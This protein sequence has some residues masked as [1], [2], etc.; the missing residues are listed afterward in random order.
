MNKYIITLFKK[1]KKHLPQKL[2]GTAF[3]EILKYG[4]LI[5]VSAWFF[6]GMLY[7]NWR[8]TILK[9]LINIIITYVFF[10]MGLPIIISLI[11]AHTLNFAFNGQLFAMYTHMGVTN[12]NPKEFLEQTILTSKRL[13]KSNSINAAI[14]YGSLSRGNFKSTSD[15][16]IRFVP[17]K[18]QIHFWRACLFAIKERVLAFLNGYP[19]DLYVFES[20]VLIKKMRSDELPIIIY[21][22]NNSM[23]KVYKNRLSMKEFVMVFT[24][25]NI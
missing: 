19:L 4:F 22:K 11:I 18:G 16:D 10:L 13:K 5:L 12:V 1:H 20:K 14:A 3:G 21:E 8:E 24:E 9:I 23:Q 15:I 2:D 17:K 6:Q 7:M 25:N